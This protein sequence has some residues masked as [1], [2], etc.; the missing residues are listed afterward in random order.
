[1][2]SARG[3]TITTDVEATVER[4]RSGGLAVIPTETVYGLAADAEQPGAVARIFS[5]KSRPP[6]HPLIVHLATP[7]TLSDGWLDPST[8]AILAHAIE[9]LATTCWPGPLTML[10]PRGPRA[11][12]AVTGGRSTVGIRVPAHPDAQRI[13]N[14]FD[15]GLAAPSA[16][17]FGRVSPTTA[18]HVLADLGVLLDPGRDIVFDGGR[19]EVGVESTIVDLSVWPPQVLRDGAVSADDIAAIIDGPLDDPGGPSRASGMLASH[20]APR[21]AVLV[22]DSPHQ[23]AT[24]A[25]HHA[26]SGE[27][28]RVLDRTADVVLAAFEL[29]SDLRAA[30]DDDLDALI[31][32]LPAARGIGHAVRDRLIKAAAGS[33]RPT[34]RVD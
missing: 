23:A 2:Q 28:V 11:L 22:A 25:A 16:N 21:C 13:L 34:N 5:V 17:R 31:V 4:L 29:Y 9:R 30:D 14:S 1:M 8:P 6:D 12:D 3:V 18:Q 10:V 26:E 7:E 32:V 27:R 15:G 20:Y 33:G 24:L 19:S